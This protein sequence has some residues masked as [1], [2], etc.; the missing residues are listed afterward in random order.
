MDSRSY[1]VECAEVETEIAGYLLIQPFD[2]TAQGMSQQR[3]AARLA[4]QIACSGWNS[5]RYP[6]ETAGLRDTRSVTIRNAAGSP[7]LEADEM[8]WTEAIA[9]QSI[10]LATTTWVLEGQDA[11]AIRF[12][13][14]AVDRPTDVAQAASEG[15]YPWRGAC[16]VREGPTLHLSHLG[17]DLSPG[18]GLDVTAIE[19]LGEANVRGGGS[20]TDWVLCR[21]PHEWW[22]TIALTDHSRG[23]TTLIGGTDAEGRAQLGNATGAAFALNGTFA[24]AEV[25][26][27]MRLA[28]A[29]APDLA[30]DASARHVAGAAREGRGVFEL[31]GLHCRATLASAGRKPADYRIAGHDL[32]GLVI[33]GLRALKEPRGAALL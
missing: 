26:A 24:Q 30:R 17:L 12:I 20:L 19:A 2:F 5:A 28:R 27:L 33:G 6:S 21:A 11:S 9:R 31:L 3:D 18:E 1:T 32:E 15:Y 22:P 23:T 29:L 13:P 8:R 4:V 25:A 7:V 14:D 10:D 16:E